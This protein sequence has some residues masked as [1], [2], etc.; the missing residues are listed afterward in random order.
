[1]SNQS[2]GLESC[3]ICAKPG[4][5]EQTTIGNL[6]EGRPDPNWRICA[7][8]HRWQTAEY[9]A[10]EAR[11]GTSVEACPRCTS[12]TFDRT[13]Y[14]IPDGMPDPN[15]RRCAC[16]ERWCTPEF[17]AWSSEVEK[18]RTEAAKRTVGFAG[19]TPIAIAHP[20]D[21][22]HYYAEKSPDG[23]VIP[24]IT[25]LIF[26]NRQCGV[27]TEREAT[28]ELRD[29]LGKAAQEA[30]QTVGGGAEWDDASAA[31][32]LAKLM[33]W[34][35]RQHYVGR[36]YRRKDGWWDIYPVVREV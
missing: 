2:P 34:V 15:E 36:V 31:I 18:E 9:L 10:W 8:G 25:V 13:D 24:G 14:P 1:M 6:L 4:P 23:A 28:Q 21:G 12:T 32:F 33:R 27:V 22:V 7:C 35:R 17:L 16:G 3:P 11:V 30:V 29:E 26:P 19:A 20:K 5:F